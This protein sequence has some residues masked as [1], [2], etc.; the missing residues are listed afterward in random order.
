MNDLL[1]VLGLQ[2]FSWY[3]YN[4]SYALVLYTTSP[5]T[6]QAIAGS[7]QCTVYIRIMY[8]HETLLVPACNYQFGAQCNP[9]GVYKHNWRI[10]IL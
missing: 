1:R 6:L 2:T 3:N 9:Y 4:I 8:I 10:W 7:Q 5:R